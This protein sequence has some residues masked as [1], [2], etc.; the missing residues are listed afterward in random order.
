ML[1]GER[2]AE[3]SDRKAQAVRDGMRRSRGRA[4]AGWL[5]RG[6]LPDGYLIVRGFDGSQVTRKA[7]KHPE[8]E[9]IIGLMWE[10]ALAGHSAQAI[11]LEFAARDYMTAPVRRNHKPRPFDVH[12]I[13]QRLANPV[14]AGLLRHKGEIIG[15]GDW[16]R[17]VE[18]EDWHRL[19]TERHERVATRRR[20]GRPVVGYLLAEVATCGVCG[21]SMHAATYRKQRVDGSSTRRYVCAAHKDF[22][23]DSPRWCPAMPFDAV[24]IDQ[25][26]LSGIDTL[27][28]DAD[29]LRAQ[30]NAGRVAEIERMG[31]IAEGAREDAA[32]ADRVAEKA[33]ERY[34]RALEEGDDAAAEI[35]LTAVKRKRDEVRKAR[36]RLDAALDALRA[37]DQPDDTDVMAKVW[38]T[39]SGRV[40]EADGE[41]RKLNAALREWFDGFELHH[42]GRRRLP[43]RARAQHR[44]R[45]PRFARARCAA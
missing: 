27:L 40:T 1:I 10:M 19:A 22:H 24:K 38:H 31:K 25:L 14:Y 36:L 9:A 23:R 44:R 28:A 45:R 39:L 7:I 4:D 5:A 11:Q 20:P 34:E 16:P 32:K 17:Y 8:R 35:A 6:I 33:Q 26:V 15:E 2:N 29:A 42:R 3:D 41:V 18:P 13:V 30:L 37:D 43:H 12:A 21:G